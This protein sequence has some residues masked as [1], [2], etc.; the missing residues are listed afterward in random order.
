MNEIM[1][2]L[3]YLNV[4]DFYFQLLNCSL[5]NL[6]KVV[7]DFMAKIEVSNVFM[8]LKLFHL[9]YKL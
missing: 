4:W 9:N 2:S 6:L 3:H 5:F 8:E 1:H 7:Q